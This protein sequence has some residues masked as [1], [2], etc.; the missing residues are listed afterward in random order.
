MGKDER[1]PYEKIAESRDARRILKASAAT[2]A[3]ILG[4]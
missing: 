3:G 1:D 4:F 2:D